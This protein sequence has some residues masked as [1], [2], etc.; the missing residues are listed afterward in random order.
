M[1]H[2][3][4]PARRR[5]FSVLQVNDSTMKRGVTLVTHPAEF[6]T[7]V[8]DATGFRVVVCDRELRA[9]ALGEQ[10]VADAFLAQVVSH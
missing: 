3:R 5:V 8:L 10:L 6:N 9:V 4:K 1:T 2:K 7:T